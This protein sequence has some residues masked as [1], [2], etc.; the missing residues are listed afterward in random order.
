MQEDLQ[1][2]YRKLNSK[3]DAKG[4]T[5]ALYR[6]AWPF[7]DDKTLQMVARLHRYVE[8][9]HLALSADS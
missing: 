3:L 7:L 8:I 9:F 2:L 4:S 1:E 6:L 5:K